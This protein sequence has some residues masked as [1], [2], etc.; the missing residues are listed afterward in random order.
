[1]KRLKGLT[2]VELLAVIVTITMLA[3][4][5]IPTLGAVNKEK[6]Y[7]AVCTNNLRA[8]AMANVAYANEDGQYYCPVTYLEPNAAGNI[9]IGGNRYDRIVWITNATFRNILGYD[10]YPKDKRNAPT[11]PS[12]SYNGPFNMPAK[13]LCPADMIS[14]D[15]QKQTSNVSMSYGYNLSDWT[16]PSNWE[17]TINNAH[18]GH[19]ISGMTNPSEKLAFIDGIDFYVNC[20]S[21]TNPPADYAIVWDQYGQQTI[22]FYKDRNL[23][24]P[25]I[26]RHNEGANI[27]FYDGHAAY[28]KKK[29]IFRARDYYTA[30]YGGGEQNPGMWVA[31]MVR[32]TGRGNGGIGPTDFFISARGGPD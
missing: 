28:M 11:S 24:G 4:I 7:R 14:I 17:R 29:Q 15:W 12:G 10:R 25:T 13:L 9:S 6:A 32:W 23:H 16:Y 30:S 22:Q 26:Y 3:A 1:M 27:G 18:A 21:K 20:G 2:A 8:F 31:D 5:L 19:T